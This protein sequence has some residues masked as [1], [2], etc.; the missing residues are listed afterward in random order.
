ML[1]SKQN[2]VVSIP[3]ILSLEDF[4]AN[5][6]EGMEWVDEMRSHLRFNP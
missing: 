6:P 3:E 1:V 4:M 5:P 2:D